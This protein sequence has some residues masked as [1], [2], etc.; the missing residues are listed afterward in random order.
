MANSKVTTDLVVDNTQMKSELKESERAVSAFGKHVKGIMI[1]VAAAFAIKI[2]FDFAKK[3]LALAN[4]QEKSEARLA[5]VIKATGGAAGFTAEQMKQLAA[6]MQNTTTFGDEV[7]LEA[8]AIIAT[9]KNIRGD[10]FIETTKAAGDM[11]VVLGTDLKSA[12][13]QLGKALNDPIKGMAV[14][15]KAGVTF[16]DAQKEMAAEMIRNGDI[17]GAQNI[18]LDE[19]KGQFEGA[20]AAMADTFG[21]KAEQLQNRLGD[22]GEV[23]GQALMPA[24]SALMNVFEGVVSWVEQNSGQITALGEKMGE[25]AQNI[26][27]FLAPAFTFMMKL[28]V[29]AFTAVQVVVENWKTALVAASFAAM[30]G[31]VKFGNVIVHWIGTVIPDLLVWFGNNWQDVWQTYSDFVI[32]IFTNM[33]EN[34][35]N[36]FSNLWVF[37]AGDD[38]NWEWKGLTEGF[39]SSLKELPKIAERVPTMLENAMQIGLDK[40]AGKLAGSFNEKFEE[41]LALFKGPEF[42][43]GDAKITGADA[44]QAALDAERGV[45]VAKAKAEKKEKED[46]GKAASFE[47]F[48]SLFNR[49]AGA[50]AGKQSPEEKTAMSTK[51]TADKVEE[52]VVTSKKSMGTLAKILTTLETIRDQ[53]VGFA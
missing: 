42:K 32:T 49:I 20:A 10:Q 25:V 4:E 12:A 15:S 16:T 44:D 7:V 1:A 41:N 11:A 36:F 52:Q 37:I 17:V 19:M 5:A 13:M 46:K 39:E 6:E 31:M 9:F 40:A 23:I 14:L 21:G 18:I 3:M 38:V 33:F 22:L 35:K 50:A 30:L 28:G 48:E 27:N 43:A 29:G 2:G 53:E 45:T 34:V 8:Q 26:I 24:L 47:G 51:K